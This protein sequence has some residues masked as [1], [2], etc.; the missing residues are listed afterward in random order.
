[1]DTAK[2]QEPAQARTHRMISEG[3]IPQRLGQ[4]HISKKRKYEPEMV[5]SSDLRVGQRFEPASSNSTILNGPQGGGQ[6]YSGSI[7]EQS[8]GELDE[9]VKS[10]SL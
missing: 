3:V 10:V 7:I 8:E 9:Q 4:R 5:P 1:M 2:C 6:R